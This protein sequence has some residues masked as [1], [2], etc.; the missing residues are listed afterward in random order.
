MFKVMRQ[1]LAALKRLLKKN[2]SLPKPTM[3]SRSRIMPGDSNRSSSRQADGFAVQ[4][5]AG[6]GMLCDT[7]DS[8]WA[9]NRQPRGSGAATRSLL[10]AR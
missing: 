3:P 10:L 5:R 7:S 2:N 9:A 1:M 4:S 6:R 8:L